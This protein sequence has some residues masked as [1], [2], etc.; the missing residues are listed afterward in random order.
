M[1]IFLIS[2][3]VKCQDFGTELW[4]SIPDLKNHVQIR[5][6]FIRQCKTIFFFKGTIYEVVMLLVNKIIYYQ[7]VE[8]SYWK[9]FAIIRPSKSSVICILTRQQ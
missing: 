7:K 3:Y 8:S 2:H 9:L 5:V 1:Y 6:V 4:L